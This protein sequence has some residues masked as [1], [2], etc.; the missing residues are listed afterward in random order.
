LKT[1]IIRES[2]WA[3]L[4]DYPDKIITLNKG[5]IIII[6]ENKYLVKHNILDL[7]NDIIQ[8]IVKENFLI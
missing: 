1:E 4:E 8:I 7:D 3:L 6:Y 2:D 5:D